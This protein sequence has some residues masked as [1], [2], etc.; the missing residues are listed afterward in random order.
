M[1][2][3]FFLFVIVLA[4]L[5]TG[6]LPWAGSEDPPDFEIFDGEATLGQQG[7][8]AFIFRGT[9]RCSMVVTNKCGLDRAVAVG[10]TERLQAQILNPQDDPD[11]QLMMISSDPTVL[12]VD[13]FEPI[14]DVAN[15]YYADVVGLAEGD[16]TLTLELPDGTVVDEISLQVRQ[17][18]SLRYFVYNQNDL[19]LQQEVGDLNIEAS[20]YHLEV[21]L[22]DANGEPLYAGDAVSFKVLEGPHGLEAFKDV[23]FIWG[24]VGDISRLR[25][26]AGDLELEFVVSYQ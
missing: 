21:R 17:A 25:A 10:G 19:L 18:A 8:M 7:R 2:S 1:K 23:A 13:S 4:T 5:F 11:Q 26:A 12:A 3:G 20:A 22:L 9:F 24:D 14:A 15:N 6:C 16:V